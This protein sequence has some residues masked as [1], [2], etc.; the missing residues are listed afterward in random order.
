MVINLAY[1]QSVPDRPLLAPM[2]RWP[3]LEDPVGSVTYYKIGIWYE[4]VF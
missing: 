3:G 2:Y 1:S 4:L